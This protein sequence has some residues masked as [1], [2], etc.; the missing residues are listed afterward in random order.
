MKN[1]RSRHNQQLKKELPLQRT[2]KKKS[3]FQNVSD[4]FLPT[5]IKLLAENTSSN[6][7]VFSNLKELE[8]HEK[9]NYIK[10]L[11]SELVECNTPSRFYFN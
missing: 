8:F 5:K 1:R 7:N 11:E 4:R 6:L 2:S 3:I 9:S 10:A